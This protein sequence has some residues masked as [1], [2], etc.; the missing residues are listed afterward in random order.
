[1][2]KNNTKSDEGSLTS[3]ASGVLVINKVNNEL[4][5]S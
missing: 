5:I 4:G 1:M 3:G 2:K